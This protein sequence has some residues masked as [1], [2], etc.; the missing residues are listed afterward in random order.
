MTPVQEYLLIGGGIAVGILALLGM[1]A[2]MYRKVGPNMALI[3]YGV[4]GSRVVTGSG[5]LVI[6]M[7]QTCR[8]LSLELMSFDVAPQNELYTHQG[9]SVLIDAVTQLKV[10]SDLE[11]VKT[12]AEQ[13]LDKP[14][15]M[16]E[17]AIRLVMEGH[18]RG[19]V[20]QLTVEEI[21]KEPEMVGEKVRS[22]CAGDL[23]KMGLEMVSF[24][25]KQVRDQ[26]E[27]IKNM[28]IPDVERV[29]KE[30]N[31]AMAEAFRD[32]E[33]RRAQAMREAAIAKAQADQE[34][35]IAETASVAK[36]SEAQRDLEIKKAQYTETVQRQRAQADKAYEIQTN[37]MQQ[38]VIAEK[39]K[40][41]QI[42]RTAQVGVQ[43]AEIGRREKELIA[44]ELKPAEVE[45]KRIQTLAEAEKARLRL[46]AEGRAEAWRQQGESEAKV[47]K[48]KGEAE[49]GIIR[50]KG[51]AEA[52]AMDVKAKA[53]RGYNEAAV[54]DKL[55]SGLPEVVRA[56]AQPLSQVDKIT[57]ISTGG[58]GNGHS[59]AGVSRVTGDITQMIAQVP[60]LIESLSGISV[61]E[62]MR[63]LPRIGPA[64]KA[65]E[66]SAAADTQA[67]RDAQLPPGKPAV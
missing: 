55:L 10:K 18:L 14:P 36:Q 51:E 65:A 47:I 6:P 49:A 53:Y 1:I 7:F 3:I 64:I 8:E 9:V 54:L 23:A 33:I 4:G 28:G 12:A 52:A 62:F 57:V 63:N 61:G 58:D 34:R 15:E 48:M 44:T 25:I 59:G 56:I 46:E 16:R 19:I 21:V 40:I 11:N 35:V 29:K 27:Y 32:T 42:E 26:N 31:I 66:T 67:R 17:S 22:T 5:A 20:G 13:F 50:M 30:A 24:T 37:T 43:E 39:V 2:R 38:Q 41:D 60:A 45:A